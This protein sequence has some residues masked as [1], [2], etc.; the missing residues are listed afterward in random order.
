MIVSLCRSGVRSL[1]LHISVYLVSLSIYFSLHVPLSIAVYRSL[2]L[3]HLFPLN[4]TNTDT[5]T[6]SD[7]QQ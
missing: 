5:T 7:I 4:Q 6:H 3:L 2:S 1:D